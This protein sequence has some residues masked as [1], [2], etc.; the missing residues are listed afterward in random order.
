MQVASKTKVICIFVILSIVSLTI[1]YL[2]LYKPIQDENNK[3][4]N[5]LSKM[6]YEI[7]EESYINYGDI[8]YSNYRDIISANNYDLMYY[9]KVI[10]YDD[11]NMSYLDRS[12]YE[13]ILTSYHTMPNTIL[14]DSNT[15]ISKY[16]YCKKYVVNNNSENIK[17]PK[18][19]KEH[20]I[21]DYNS[22]SGGRSMCEVTWKKQDDEKWVIMNF[23]ES[24]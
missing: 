13:D 5:K 20:T 24:P 7:V 17:F 9:L 10:N 12:E 11:P 19:S 1:L 14:I 16:E 2:F 23:Y 4:C 8:N 6:V 22:Y 18:H 15:A 21:Y 3:T